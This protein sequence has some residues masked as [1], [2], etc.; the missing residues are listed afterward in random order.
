MKG[1]TICGETLSPG[2]KKQTVLRIP[3]GSLK[4]GGTVGPGSRGG[5]GYEI[6]A[7]LICGAR[8][9]K[10]VLITASIHSGEYVGVPA[11]IRV[12]G[13]LE[14]ERLTGNLLLLPCVNTSGFWAHSQAVL[15]EDGFNLNHQYPG[16]PNGTVGDRIADY[17]VREIFPC[18]DFILD[19]H[20]GGTAEH[21]APLVFFPTWDGARETALA[22]A[23]AMNVGFLIESEARFG[24]YSYAAHS[25]GIPGL[26]LE[27]GSGFFCTAEESEAD[28]ADIRLALD[29][30][31]LYPA[32]PGTRDETMARR[33]FREAIYLEAADQGL[34]YHAV[35]VGDDVKK[36]DLLGRMEDFFGNVIAEYR[37]ERDGCILYETCGLA[38]NRGEFLVAYAV[39]DSEERS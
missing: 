9:G 37:A 2:E 7:T 13:E 23:K 19:F 11:V 26:L 20:G 28:C 18:V 34:W 35:H 16:N 6:P 15:P 22:T 3:M 1:W 24:Q 29:H 12:A 39:L 8:P 38:V 27:R 31:G 32:E 10:T 21:M 17:F 30:L 36:G 5:E 14:A 4:H 33:V 25:L